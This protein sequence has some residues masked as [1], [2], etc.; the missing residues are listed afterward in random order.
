MPTACISRSKLRVVIRVGSGSIA[1]STL[2]I[3]WV[4]PWTEAIA[5]SCASGVVRIT[6]SPSP[7]RR[8]AAALKAP[9]PRIGQTAIFR[10]RMP[11]P[12]LCG[13]NSGWVARIST[14]AGNPAARIAAGPVFT[15]PTS[16]TSVPGRRCGARARTASSRRVTGVARIT[17]GQAATRRRS[18]ATASGPACAAISPAG[19][20]GSWIVRRA[21]GARWRAIRRPKAPK[22]TRPT[23][24]AGREG[25]R[26]DT[27]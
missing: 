12:A 14:S 10:P 15:E 23:D 27:L 8:K 9:R 2:A 22:P 11:S 3:R 26:A 1:T 16:T 7:R 4:R 19:R 5:R 17:T 18:A 21:C 20:Y 6:S 24:G 13:P 25:C